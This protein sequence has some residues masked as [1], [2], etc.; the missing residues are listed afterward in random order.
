MI[1]DLNVILTENIRLTCS[2]IQV[3]EAGDGLR[4]LP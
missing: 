4:S 2:M 3:V 1:L